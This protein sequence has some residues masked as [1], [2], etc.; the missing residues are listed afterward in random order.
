M[1]FLSQC[2]SKIDDI[3][4]VPVNLRKLFPKQW[5]D[6]IEKSDLD[7]LSANISTPFLP[8]ETE[9]F[10]ALDLS[11]DEVR[12][13]IV[14]Q[15]PYPNPEHAMGLA[16]SV[17]ENVRPLP[18][19]LRNIFLE[20]E[21]DLGYK[22]EEGDLSDWSKQGILLLNRSLTVGEGDANSHKNIGWELITDPIISYVAKNNAVGILW[23][24]AAAEAQKYFDESN[25]IISAHPSPLSSYRGF[26][27]SK[28]FSRVN[29]ILKSRGE[30]EIKW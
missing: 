11:P 26:F 10:R 27:G 21:N 29:T 20:L 15:D 23:G 28:P 9:I 7:K 19:S 14:G 24:K 6:I 12:V 8:N 4:P 30:I 2:N 13:V 17:R 18:A 5:L 3:L 16:F 1:A 22:R 25:R